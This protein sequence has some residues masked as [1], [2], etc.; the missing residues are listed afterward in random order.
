[1]TAQYGYDIKYK[2]NSLLITMIDFSFF[3]CQAIVAMILLDIFNLAVGPSHRA[4]WSMGNQ[5][6]VSQINLIDI[7]NEQQGRL[8]GLQTK[9][10]MNELL[11]WYGMDFIWSGGYGN[12]NRITSYFL[13][14]LYNSK[15]FSFLIF[16]YIRNIRF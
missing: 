7:L 1:M 10:R 4:W 16:V 5:V 11:S 13:G 12:G 3:L 6:A 14:N 15:H 8:H 9:L 2:A